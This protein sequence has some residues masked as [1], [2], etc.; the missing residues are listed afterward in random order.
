MRSDYRPTKVCAR[1]YDNRRLRHQLPPIRAF[2]NFRAIIKIRTDAVCCIHVSTVLPNQLLSQYQSFAVTRCQIF[3]LKC[4]KFNFG[5]GYAPD[6]AGGAYS[7]PRPLA[8]GDEAGCPLPKNTAPSRP[9]GSQNSV[10]GA[11][12]F[13]HSGLGTTSSP[14][15]S[16]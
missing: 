6:P 14:D 7:A 5:W 11:S 4:T 2:T 15:P 8:G 12:T 1:S 9:F 13:G 16:P 10:L 3:R